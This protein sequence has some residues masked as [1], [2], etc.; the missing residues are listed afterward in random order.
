MFVIFSVGVKRSVTTVNGEKCVISFL[1][2][3]S[4]KK[5]VLKTVE[6]PARNAC[7]ISF[8]SLLVQGKYLKYFV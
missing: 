4:K 3:S 7:N 1:P 2:T 8:P 5:K 6:S